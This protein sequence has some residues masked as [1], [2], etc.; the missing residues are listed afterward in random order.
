MYEVLK[1][2][3]NNEIN[4][5]KGKIVD[6]NDKKLASSLLEAGYIKVASKKEV[7]S[8]EKD[9]EIKKL[10]TELAEKDAIIGDL[11]TK[12]AELEELL[13]TLGNTVGE[14]DNSDE[15][16]KNEKEDDNTLN[17]S[18]NESKGNKE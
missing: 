8:K 5:T 4:A 12:I 14:T 11:Q 9:D 2:F 1:G 18:N 6:I 17:D 7:S 10:S 16:N 3:A 15:D 13:S